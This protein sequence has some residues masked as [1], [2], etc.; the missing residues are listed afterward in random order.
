MFEVVGQDRKEKPAWWAT[1]ISVAV[2][3]VLVLLLVFGFRQS[4]RLG[5]PT[6]EKADRDPDWG[7]AEC[8][9]IDPKRGDRLGASDK[10]NNNGKA[11]G[12]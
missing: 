11:I 9:M 4:L 12:F 1:A 2:H 5:D 3:A 6:N 8:I 10:R 7:D